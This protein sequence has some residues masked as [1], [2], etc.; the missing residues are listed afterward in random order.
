MIEFSNVKYRILFFVGFFLFFIYRRWRA[1]VDWNAQF[2]EHY[3]LVE[4]NLVDNYTQ[5]IIEQNRFSDLANNIPKQ[6]F[7]R[8]LSDIQNVLY[9][10]LDERIDRRNETIQELYH[11]GFT[12]PQRLPAIKFTP[13]AVGCSLSHIKALE[14]AQQQNWDHVLIC[15]DD[16]MFG[17][18]TMFQERMDCFLQLHDDWDVLLLGGNI[19]K[20]LYIDSCSARVF[21]TSCTTA[22]LVRRE[23]YDVLLHNFKEGARRLFNRIPESYIDVF[24]NSL[25]ARDRWYT[26]LPVPVLQRPGQSDIEDREVDYRQLMIDNALK[27]IKNY[28]KKEKQWFE[29]MFAKIL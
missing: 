15:E 29:Q 27:S 28:P 26:V 7:I 6:T 10:N 24:W 19:K 14:Y 17:D 22:Y 5:P 13:G 12:N 8:C 16:V 4:M 20:G 21:H 18:A 23:Y 2:K 9:I 1:Y 3:T 11:V 25:V